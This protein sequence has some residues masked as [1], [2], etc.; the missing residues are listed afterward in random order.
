MVTQDLF[1]ILLQVRAGIYACNQ[2]IRPE[3]NYG[4][5]IFNMAYVIILLL[6]FFVIPP[7]VFSFFWGKYYY[8]YYYQ[9]Y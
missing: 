3:C 6:A 9:Q 2:M 4:F 7:K 1:D 8:Y 5:Q